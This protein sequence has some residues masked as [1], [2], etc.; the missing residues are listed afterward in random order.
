MCTEAM[1]KE[2]FKDFKPLDLSSFAFTGIKCL[3]VDGFD[4][5]TSEGREEFNKSKHGLKCYIDKK[6]GLI[7]IEVI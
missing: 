3:M 6:S 5:N 1:N 4:L 7:T 2:D